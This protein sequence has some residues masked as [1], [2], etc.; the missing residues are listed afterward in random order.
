MEDF[1]V[2]LQTGDNWEAMKCWSELRQLQEKY[3]RNANELSILGF[4]V[5][6]FFFGVLARPWI[7]KK[8]T[9]QWPPDPDVGKFGM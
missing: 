3:D 9:G 8:I 5:L 2:F 1:I 6:A 7:Q 4:G